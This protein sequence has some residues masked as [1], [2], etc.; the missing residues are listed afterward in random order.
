VTAPTTEDWLFAGLVL[1]VFAPPWALMVRSMWRDDELW[2]EPPPAWFAG[3]TQWYATARACA[4][5]LMVLVSVG[6]SVP[7]FAPLEEDTA[8]YGLALGVFMITGVGGLVAVVSTAFWNWPKF[9]VPPPRRAD[10][11]IFGQKP[12]RR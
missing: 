9:L 3:R 4:S 12:A 11:P 6:L 10:P 1:V 8:A 7:V 2:R 5:M